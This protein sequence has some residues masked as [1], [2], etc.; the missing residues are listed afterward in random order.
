VETT[1]GEPPLQALFSEN[2]LCL[3]TGTPC[4]RARRRRTHAAGGRGSSVL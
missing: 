2:R 4:R 3:R 1:N